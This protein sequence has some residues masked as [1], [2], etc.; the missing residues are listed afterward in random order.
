VLPASIEMEMKGP[1]KI[2]IL[3][4]AHACTWECKHVVSGR[5]VLDAD[6]KF[7]TKSIFDRVN[8]AATIS[9]LLRFLAQISILQQISRS[10]CQELPTGSEHFLY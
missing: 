8:T 1:P 5:S 7:H 6:G 3:A 2:I 4:T 9:V 10:A